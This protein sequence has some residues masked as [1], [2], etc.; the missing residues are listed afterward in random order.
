MRFQRPFLFCTKTEE[1][2]AWKAVAG[3][4]GVCIS[5]KRL[6]GEK[7]TLNDCK[8]NRSRVHTVRN[9]SSVYKNFDLSL[10]LTKSSNCF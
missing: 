3:V 1:A 9:D 2:D 5:V 7:C 10:C 4:A 6:Q 8:N